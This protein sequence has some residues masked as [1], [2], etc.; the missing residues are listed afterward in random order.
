L[1][2]LEKINFSGKINLI[3][4][5]ISLNLINSLFKN[6][7]LIIYIDDFYVNHY[8]HYPHF[9]IILKK[10]DNG[11]RIFDPLDG[12]IKFVEAKKLS[13]AIKSLR[14]LLKFCPKLIQLKN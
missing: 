9:V 5:K 13:R 14:N 10:Q 1:K 12:K 4:E 2:I 8:I 7:P 6:S 11:F 3:R